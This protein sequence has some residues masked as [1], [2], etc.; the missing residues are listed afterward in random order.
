MVKPDWSEDDRGI[1]SALGAA[2]VEI[3][4]AKELSQEGL[5]QAAGIER[6]HMGKL[7]RGKR[8]VTLLSLTKIADALG[9]PPSHLLSKAGF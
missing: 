9:V 1:L 3:R 6:A 4:K 8:N 5:A 7:E 2:I